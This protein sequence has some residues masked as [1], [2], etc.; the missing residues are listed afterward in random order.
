MNNIIKNEDEF[1][2]HL[3]SDRKHFKVATTDGA[4][5][6]HDFKELIKNLHSCGY[7]FAKGI[8]DENGKVRYSV[9]GLHIDIPK[10]RVTAHCSRWSLNDNPAMRVAPAT[11]RKVLY[12]RARVQPDEALK[13]L[14]LPVDDLEPEKETPAVVKT[15]EIIPDA[16]VILQGPHRWMKSSKHEALALAKLKATEHPQ[17]PVKICEVHVVGTV[18]SEIKIDFNTSS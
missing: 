15:P 2:A 17:N 9:W 1:M 4:T 12:N 14:D 8:L 6:T 16:F 11:A 5:K 13:Q 3:Y 7:T 18:T 10:K